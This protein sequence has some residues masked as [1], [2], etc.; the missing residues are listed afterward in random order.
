MHSL[1]APP[2]QTTEFNSAASEHP[3]LREAQEYPSS[4]STAAQ[5]HQLHST[6]SVPD[7]SEAPMTRNVHFQRGMGLA[8][9]NQIEYLNCRQ[10]HNRASE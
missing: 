9:D 7:I 8:F 1:S 2:R 10:V 6:D 3:I 5:E 4:S